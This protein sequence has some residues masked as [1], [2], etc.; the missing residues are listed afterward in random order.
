[1]NGGGAKSLD[2]RRPPVKNRCEQPGSFSIP[3]K[4]RRQELRRAA[5]GKKKISRIRFENTAK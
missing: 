2:Y 4:N 1:M 5:K 3:R